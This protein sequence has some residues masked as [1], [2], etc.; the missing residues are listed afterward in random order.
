MS[1]QEYNPLIGKNATSQTK[2]PSQ[3]ID[4]KELIDNPDKKVR[5]NLME[6]K[7]SLIIWEEMQEKER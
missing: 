5:I 6:D 4:L 3:R 1:I 2:N 7:D